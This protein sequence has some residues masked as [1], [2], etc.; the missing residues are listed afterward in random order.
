MHILIFWAFKQGAS[1]GACAII[2]NWGAVRKCVR[3]NYWSAEVRAA[4]SKISRNPTSGPYI[5]F[6]K[7]I[8]FNAENQ[9]FYVSSIQLT[10][11]FFGWNNS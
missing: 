8:Y 1:A 4:H 3:N 10:K 2:K 9:L 7:K 5:V 11:V 6:I